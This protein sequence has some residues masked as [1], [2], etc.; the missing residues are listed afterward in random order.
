MHNDPAIPPAADTHSPEDARQALALAMTSSGSPTDAAQLLALVNAGQWRREERLLIKSSIRPPVYHAGARMPPAYGP[1]NDPFDR[2]LFYTLELPKHYNRQGAAALETLLRRCFDVSSVP[3]TPSIIASERMSG[4][5]GQC[6]FAGGLRILVCEGVE[7]A[8]R[9][10]DVREEG[11]GY[12]LSVQ[13]SPERYAQ[14]QP[15][16][17]EGCRPGLAHPEARQSR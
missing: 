4:G 2:P 9:V 6:Y 17:D 15:L 8:C 7:L 13:L 10:G 12:L 14:L 1:E 5:P 3:A 11:V 16:I